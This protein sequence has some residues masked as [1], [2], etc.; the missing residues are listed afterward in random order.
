MWPPSSG[1]NTS[2]HSCG[3]RAEAPFSTT[4]FSH[5]PLSPTVARSRIFFLASTWKK[6]GHFWKKFS[7]FSHI[8][9]KQRLAEGSTKLEIKFCYCPWVFVITVKEG[10]SFQKFLRPLFCHF[11]QN[12]AKSRPKILP[13]NFFFLRPLLSFLAGISATWQHCSPPPRYSLLLH[14]AL[15]QSSGVLLFA[16][17]FGHEDFIKRESLL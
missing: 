11:W 10:N 8:K 2:P 7:Q 9:A 14:R 3:P 1:V 16:R 4:A 5:S 12:S 15:A 6:F 13:A 17:R